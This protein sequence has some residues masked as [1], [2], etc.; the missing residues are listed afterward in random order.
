M[1]F[2]SPL[3]SAI[4][5][6]V[7]HSDRKQPI[8]LHE[9]DFTS[10]NAWSYV[11]SCLDTAWVSTAGEWVTRFEDLLSL[12]T[13]AKFAIAVSNGTNALRLG[14]HLLGVQ[15]D[16]EVLVP[17]LSFVATANAVSGLINLGNTC[18]FNGLIQ[19]TFFSVLVY[20]KEQRKLR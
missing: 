16:E 12:H 14:L 15:P 13:G 17:S 8:V 3:F 9:P 4:Q 2:A 11:K 6:V 19:S 5:S 18:F 20:F 10:T 7:C 1:T